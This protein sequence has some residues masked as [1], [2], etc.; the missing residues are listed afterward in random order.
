ME[1]IYCQDKDHT[2]NP[3]NLFCLDK[4]CQN[5]GLIC[6]FCLLNC[7]Q[8]HVNNVFPLKTI[9]QNLN[10]ANNPKNQQE[11]YNKGNQIFEKHHKIKQTF[12]QNLIRI[13]E[14]LNK[15]EKE[16]EKQIKVLDLEAGLF[17]GDAFEKSISVLN[18]QKLQKEQIEQAIE[19]IEPLLKT[20]DGQIWIL[21]ES[22][23]NQSAQKLIKI[24]EVIERESKYWLEKCLLD[25]NRLYET[26]QN[27]IKKQVKI[28]TSQ[29]RYQLTY[30]QWNLKETDAI[31]FRS[32]KKHDI[33]LSG[34]GLYE[35]TTRSGITTSHLRFKY[36][37]VQMS[38]GLALINC[39][40]SKKVIY[41]DTFDVLPNIDYCNHIGKMCFNKAIKIEFDQPYTIA[42][43][44]NQSCLS[45]Y[46]ANGKLETE[47]FQFSEPSF[48]QEFSDNSTTINQRRVIPHF[49]YEE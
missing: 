23:I 5:K 37:K 33:W 10:K 31:S 47:E 1:V 45:Y 27:P 26:C 41:E 43:K 44:P 14:I 15:L 21:R 46:G 38:I 40:F 39:I 13:K 48:T 12:R 20:C 28:L 17:V 16:I 24:A 35:I 11:L 3:L 49:Y 9:V 30:E 6:S 8:E 36:L 7:H 25:L 42:L 29:N 4:E 32:K 18:K 19:K 22:E 2:G 34:V